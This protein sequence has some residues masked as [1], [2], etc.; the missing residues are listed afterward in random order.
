MTHL[1]GDGVAVRDRERAVDRDVQLGDE[2]VTEPARL[3]GVNRR[4]TRRC[5]GGLLDAVDDGGIDG[6]HQPVPDLTSGAAQHG[7]DRD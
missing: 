7:E 2:A 1:G 4:D 3:H 6:V 5:A